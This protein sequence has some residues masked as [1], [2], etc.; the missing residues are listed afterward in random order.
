MYRVDHTTLRQCGTQVAKPVPKY[1]VN[2]QESVAYK[3]KTGP[4]FQRPVLTDFIV[5]EVRYRLLFARTFSRKTAYTF[6]PGALE[7]I[8]RADTGHIIGC[9]NV[10]ILAKR[11][12]ALLAKVIVQ[13]FSAG[14]NI[15][16]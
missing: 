6:S 3:R 8:I 5:F 10:E 2:H 11:A 13:Q 7:V 1:D 15:I 14:R 9:V 16:G 12:V 4:C